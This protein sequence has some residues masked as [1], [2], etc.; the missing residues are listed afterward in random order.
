[1]VISHIDADGLFATSALRA[2]M[3]IQSLNGNDTKDMTLEDAKL[4]I[5]SLDKP[6]KN[7]RCGIGF[8]NCKTS[9]QLLVGYINPN[10]LFSDG[11]LK[12]GMKINSINGKCM[13]G[14]KMKPRHN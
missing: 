11:K 3:K 6:S 5:K 4:L 2:G 8:V 14:V 1:M 12:I 9:G 7:D 13:D 10:G